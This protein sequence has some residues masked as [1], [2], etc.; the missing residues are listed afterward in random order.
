MRVLLAVLLIGIVGCGW[1][2]IDQGRTD[3]LLDTREGCKS[4]RCPA[5]SLPSSSILTNKFFDFTRFG[6]SILD[7]SSERAHV[8]RDL[9][10]FVLEFV[11]PARNPHEW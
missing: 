8:T 1:C 2:V 11:D 10:L 6:S 7:P 4:D 3:G 9:D 5:T